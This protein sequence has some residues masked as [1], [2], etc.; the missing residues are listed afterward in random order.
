MEHTVVHFCVWFLFLGV[1][2]VRFLQVVVHINTV[3]FLLLSN[4][5]L[6]VNATICLSIHLLVNIWVVVSS[7]EVIMSVPVQV[8]FV[9]I[10]FYFSWLN[11]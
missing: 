7:D 6:Y 4:I 2:F 9:D 8:F 10:Y 1:M 11:T 3:F 5:P